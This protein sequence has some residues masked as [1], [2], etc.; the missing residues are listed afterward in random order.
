MD[1]LKDV[2]AIVSPFVSLI[3]TLFLMNIKSS[4]NSLD[5]KIDKAESGL[6]DLIELERE[7][8]KELKEDKVNKEF[9]NE[10]HKEAV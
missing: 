1:A 9:C 6:K 7:A 4:L 3:I 2:F 10:R 5:K 8:I